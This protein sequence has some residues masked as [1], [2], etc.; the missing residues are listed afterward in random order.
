M[1]FFQKK[2]LNTISKDLLVGLKVFV[3]FLNI[4][5]RRRKYANIKK[6]Y[7]YAVLNCT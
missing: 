1:R 3:V 6:Y 7:K 4:V 5:G 2:K